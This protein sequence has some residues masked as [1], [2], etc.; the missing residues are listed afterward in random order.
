[1]S[2]L[3]I[4]VHEP[5]NSVVELFL[6]ATSVYSLKA[7]ILSR[8]GVPRQELTIQG[9]EQVHKSKAVQT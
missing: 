3:Q 1:M 9:Q 2:V 8:T 6:A 7:L 5:L 4:R